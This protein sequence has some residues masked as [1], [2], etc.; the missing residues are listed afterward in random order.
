MNDL[1]GKVKFREEI[2]NVQAQMQGMIVDGVAE[3]VTC[4]E[5]AGCDEYGP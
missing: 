4:V 5:F 3:F 1:V 2:L